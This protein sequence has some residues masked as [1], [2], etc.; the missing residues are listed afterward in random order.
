MQDLAEHLARTVAAALPRLRA[1]PPDRARVRPRPGAWCPAELVGHLV[2]SAQVNLERFL[3]AQS[4]DDLSLPGYPQDD[5]VAVQAYAYADWSELVETWRL[6][7]ARVA[8]VMAATPP[9]V[10][11]RQRPQHNLQ[12]IG[13]A[14]FDPG[15]AV[16]LRAFMADYV[17]HLEHH[18]ARLFSSGA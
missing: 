10:A 3:R 4:R 9:E 15:A 18:L 12:E 5:W 7:N 17:G 16:T 14:A 8:V 6:L 11:E 1:L 13:W 2:D